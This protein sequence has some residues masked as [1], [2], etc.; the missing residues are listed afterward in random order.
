MTKIIRIEMCEDCPYNDWD[1]CQRLSDVKCAV[2]GVRDDCPLENP[3]AE[4]S[5]IC[6]NCEQ[7]LMC[8]QDGLPFCFGCGYA[9][10][11]E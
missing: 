11:E 9:S 3:T 4:P 5:D 7:P 10:E 8:G 6:P 1:G 2:N